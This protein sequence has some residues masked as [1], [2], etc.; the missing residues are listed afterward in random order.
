MKTG[1]PQAGPR[2]TFS[3]VWIVESLWCLEAKLKLGGAA[4]PLLD[5]LAADSTGAVDPAI[6]FHTTIS[7]SHSNLPNGFSEYSQISRLRVEYSAICFM[8]QRGLRT[9]ASRTD[10]LPSQSLCNR[11][12]W[13]D[14]T[15]PR[16]FLDLPRY[17]RHRVLLPLVMDRCDMSVSR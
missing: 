14:I 1:C 4:Y 11:G 5:Q 15:S 6:S 9:R 7:I 13:K 16:K 10:G 17:R 12:Q 2:G 8:T 3:L